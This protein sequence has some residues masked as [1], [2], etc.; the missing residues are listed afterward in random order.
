MKNLQIFD[1]GGKTIDRITAIDR[2]S[3]ARPARVN[4][5]GTCTLHGTFAAVCSSYTGAGIYVH[6]EIKRQHIGRHLGKR[7]KFADLTPE[8]QNL[9]RSEFDHLANLY[10]G[11]EQIHGT[12]LRADGERFKF[13]VV[14]K[15]RDKTPDCCISSFGAS[16]YFRTKYGKARN[17][18]KTLHT[19]TKA[20]ERE[21]FANME[22]V[23]SVEMYLTDTVHIF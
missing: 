6:D 15:G 19:L 7:V 9:L 5:D 21:I 1:N 18:Y 4:E 12:I 10:N 2:E 11:T 23:L 3:M 16:L 8:L 22:D 20:I 17:A 14:T 13:H